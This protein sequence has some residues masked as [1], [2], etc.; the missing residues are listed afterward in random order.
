MSNDAFL[1]LFL[2]L[3]ACMA[4]FPLIFRQIKIPEVITLMII[5]MVIGPNGFDLVGHLSE[6]LVIFGGNAEAIEQNAMTLINSLGSLGLLFLMTLAGME[7]DFK[8]LDSSRKPVVMLSILTF[9]IPAVSGFL[10]YKFFE[11]DDLPGQLLYAS[12]F[13]SHSVG[14]VFPVIR[15]LNLTRTIFGV[16]VLIST[17]ITDILS[18]IL[19]AVSVQMKKVEVG[20][21]VTHKTLS[22]FD[23]MDPATFGNA[24]IWVFL[25]IVVVY[26]IAVLYL[27]PKL[28]RLILKCMPNGEDSI[29]WCFLFVILLTVMCGELLGIN[30]VVGAFLAGLGLSQIVKMKSNHEGPTLFQ[31]LEGIGYGLLIPFLFLSIGMKTNFRVLFEASGNLT[32]VLLTVV[33]LVGSKVFSGWLALKLCNFRDAHGICAGVMTVPQLSATLAAAAIGK[34]LGMLTDNFF[35]A[36]VVL[37]IVTTLPVPNIVRWIIEHYQLKFVPIGTQKKTP[38]EL[39]HAKEDELI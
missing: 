5:G 22:I 21:N 34:D 36:I 32:I 31:K 38:F 24:F 6:K 4:L 14:I 13:A 7:A 16:A 17:V 26:F 27:T 15:Q 29:T 12:L 18:I 3:L 11:A 33:G 37:S 30:L 8:A 39:P 10:V 23:Y 35:N 9:A 2:I 19:L 1:I 20:G 25:F 28:G